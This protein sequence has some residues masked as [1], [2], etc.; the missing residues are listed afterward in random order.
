MDIWP[1]QQ[2]LVSQLKE[3]LMN[4]KYQNYNF[5]IILEKQCDST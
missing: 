4:A 2:M 5:F 1:K 3:M